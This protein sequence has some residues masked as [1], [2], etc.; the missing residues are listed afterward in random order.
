MALLKIY[1]FLMCVQ[2]PMP[3]RKHWRLFF[4]FMLLYPLFHLLCFIFLT[5]IIG[6][7]LSVVKFLSSREIRNHLLK[8]LKVYMISFMFTYLRINWFWSKDDSVLVLRL[9]FHQDWL[10]TS[11][12]GDL[13]FL[14]GSYYTFM[15]KKYNCKLDFLQELRYKFWIWKY[16]FQIRKYG[17]LPQ[18]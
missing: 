13:R 6:N 16:F 17:K 4:L 14:W 11:F 1:L 8:N 5:W 12:E 15:P 2:D 3:S 7:Y 18:Y 9:F 10:L